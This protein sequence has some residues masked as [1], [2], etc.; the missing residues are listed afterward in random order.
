MPEKV[1]EKI[2]DSSPAPIFASKRIKYVLLSISGL[3]TAASFISRVFIELYA[4]I[5]GSSPLILSLITAL[6]NLIQQTFQSTFGRI[7]DVIGRKSLIIAGLMTSGI[8][9]SLFPLIK[10]GWILVI[11][12]VIYS[13]GF[14]IYTPS[15][16][17][18]QGDITTKKNRAGLIS[19]VTLVGA[20]ASLMGLI[21]V[22][23]ISNLGET[24]LN[25]YVIILQIT[26]ALFIMTAIISVLLTDTNIERSTERA[27]FSLKPFKENKRFRNFT[28]VNLSMGFFMACGWPI[29]PYVRVEYA[30]AFENSLIWAAFSIFQITTLILTKKYIDQIG[31]KKLLFFGRVL[32]WF[33]PFNL[34]I[35]ILWFPTWYNMMLGSIVSGISNALFMVGQ[36]SYIF[37]C[38]SIK[39][40]GTYTGVHNF[41]I[42]LSTFFGSLIMGVIAS[43]LFVVIGKWEALL[44]LLL[45]T[46]IGRLGASFGYLLVKE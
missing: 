36:N 12:V 29:F 3:A 25:Q 41:F 16:T 42:G 26:S 20:L 21:V 11:G 46:T 45:I 23:F 8:T 14:A 27:I 28:I 33:I 19:L 9:L 35:T 43:A 37:D 39:D 31:R 18:V 5:I 6:K 22:G 30:S 32:M 34:I 13:I 38:A 15:F 24:S 2:I 10:S 1:L 7:S 40:K 44:L 4:V 17:A